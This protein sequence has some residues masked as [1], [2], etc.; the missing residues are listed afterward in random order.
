MSESIR[1]EQFTARTR[2]G[3]VG[4]GKGARSVAVVQRSVAGPYLWALCGHASIDGVESTRDE[5]E[6]K[7]EAAYRHARGLL[8]SVE[9]VSP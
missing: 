5:A 8:G 1:W 6:R 3:Y 9:E 4:A 7:A 2:Y